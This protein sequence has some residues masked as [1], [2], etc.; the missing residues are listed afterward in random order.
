MGNPTYLPTTVVREGPAKGPG[1]VYVLV[2]NRSTQKPP[3]REPTR[4]E[5]QYVRVTHGSLFGSSSAWPNS[6]SASAHEGS[7][8]FRPMLGI[9]KH[10]TS[11]VNSANNKARASVLNA[12]GATA[13]VGINLIQYRQ[14]TEMMGNRLFQLYRFAKA[15]KRF[16]ILGAADALGVH[17][18]EPAVLAI[19]KR[20]GRM[21]RLPNGKKRKYASSK[22]AASLWLEFWF[23]WSPLVS[24]IYACADFLS[25]DVPGGYFESSKVSPVKFEEHAE[26]ILNPKLRYPTAWSE[27]LTG[28]VFAKAGGEFYVSNPNLYLA[29][30]LGLVN[31]A[32]IVYDAI[33]FSFVA[34][35]FINIEQFISSYSDLLGLKI[36]KAWYANTVVASYST[37]YRTYDVRTGVTTSGHTYTKESVHFRRFLGV[38]D[39][40]L[41][42]HRIERIS[43]TR[44]ATAISLL[45]QQ[46][47]KWKS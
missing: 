45:I 26:G 19:S 46:L 29:N 32:I 7:L 21:R 23:G 33:P 47:P 38:A 42:P 14:S 27:D 16:D 4:Y 36:E 22:Q 35:W 6:S 39:V 17:R 8:D 37:L 2:A 3:L 5:R 41:L 18:R 25:S 20:T 34:N 12:L 28:R 1:S 31:P 43:L 13:G 44:A 10:V 24:D 30:R 9:T 11:A 15:V 40:K